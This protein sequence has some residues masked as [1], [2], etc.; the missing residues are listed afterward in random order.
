MKS[1]TY[2][3][4]SSAC[5]AG[6]ALLLAACG[7]QATKGASAST[8]DEAENKIQVLESK[9]SDALP[10]RAAIAQLEPGDDASVFG[11]IGG[12]KQP[13]LEGYAGF[14]LGDTDIMFCDEMGEKHCPTP[15]D[16]CCEDSDK[17]KASRASVQFVD[18]A[19]NPLATDLEGFA[20]LKGLSEVTVLGRVADSSTPENLILEAESIY[21]AD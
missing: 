11:Q 17:L 21:I 15:W 5:L 14:V 19:G 20:G 9:P 16:A 10:V 13:F 8:G 1:K 2:R 7:E 18:A 3:Y 12:T 6:L 4:T